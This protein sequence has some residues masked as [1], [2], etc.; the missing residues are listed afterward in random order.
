MNTFV[1]ILACL[2]A[3]TLAS[4]VDDV[5][6]EFLANGEMRCR[7]NCNRNR[8]RNN[9][10]SPWN[11]CPPTNCPPPFRPPNC[12]APDCS[13]I[14]NRVR[15]VHFDHPSDP[16]RFIVCAPL[17]AVTWAPK[18]QWCG[19]GTLFSSLSDPA[20]CVHPWEWRQVCTSQPMDPILSD[21]NCGAD[22]P[23]CE[24]GSTP[25]DPIPSTTTTTRLPDNCP[26][27]CVPCVWWPCQPCQSNCACNNQQ[28][29][30][31]QPRPPMRPNNPWEQPIQQPRPPM[32]PNNPWEQQ[33]VD[34]VWPNHP[35]DQTPNNPWNQEP[36]RRMD[37]EEEKEE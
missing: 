4:P 10:I 14:A 28:Q 9:P 13:I 27:P 19:C 6:V 20:R 26:C 34:P 7:T 25:G 22:C 3:V 37:A 12:G 11:D 17:D 2:T 29:P 8:N 21:E 32:R 18:E 23:D 15:G 35:W 24:N 16:N 33:P 30:I 31:Q 5:I 36:W 1:V